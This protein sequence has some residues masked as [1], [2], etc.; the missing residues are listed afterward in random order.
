MATP[1]LAVTF[2]VVAAIWRRSRSAIPIA[3]CSVPTT[4]MTNSSPPIRAVIESLRRVRRRMPAISINVWSPAACPAVSLTRL[5]ASR[6]TIK[7]ARTAEPLPI[8]SAAR[9]RTDRLKARRFGSSVS[10]SVSDLSASV[11]RMCTS[12]C[13]ENGTGEHAYQQDQEFAH[14]HGY[15]DVLAVL[16][17]QNG[18]GAR[19]YQRASMPD[20]GWCE[21]TRRSRRAPRRPW[22][23]ECPQRGGSGPGTTRRYRRWRRSRTPRID[24][25]WASASARARPSPDSKRSPQAR[26]PETARHRCRVLIRMST[27]TRPRMD[28]DAGNHVA[29]ESLQIM[30]SQ[31]RRQPL[32]MVG[33]PPPPANPV[34]YVALTLCVV[35]AGR[36]DGAA[37]RSEFIQTPS[38]QTPDN[39]MLPTENALC[40]H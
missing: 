12:T 7:T 36:G 18:R 31:I 14:G 13:A 28:D 23:P 11:P 38:R 39:R 25:G 6:S 5:K 30:G 33:L 40:W 9:V 27:G 37:A 34:H 35:G 24:H 8:D 4:A 16:N 15:T 20:I 3:A 10:G 29:G 17:R 19:R 22:R 32:I 2:H 21:R 26:S 1:T